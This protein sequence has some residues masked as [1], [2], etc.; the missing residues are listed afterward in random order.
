MWEK[1]VKKLSKGVKCVLIIDGY[2]HAVV[3]PDTCSFFD[4]IYGR[5]RVSSGRV[6]CDR[7]SCSTEEPSTNELILRKV[8]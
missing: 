1:K 2:L 5:V 6:Q 7:Y 8:H 4:V 3:C